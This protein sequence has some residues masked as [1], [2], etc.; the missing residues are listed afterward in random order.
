MLKLLFYLSFVIFFGKR[1]PA[2]EDYNLKI[3]ISNIKY[4]GKIILHFMIMQKILIQ[5]M[6]L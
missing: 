1:S 2:Y 4:S 3:V 6:N 5:M